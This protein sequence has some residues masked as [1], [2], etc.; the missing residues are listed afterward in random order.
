MSGS[1]VFCIGFPKTGTTTLE[2]VLKSLGYRMGSQAHGE[3]LVESW[4]NRNFDPIKKLCDTADAFQDV[5]FGLP[6]TFQY[7]DSSYPDSKFILS[8][9]NNPDQWYRSVVNFH[10]KLWSADKTRPPSLSELKK[11]NYN[12]LG[13][14]YNSMKAIYNTTDNDI[15]NRERLIY[16]YLRHIDNVK[17][18]FTRIPDR[19]II[20]NVSID[21]DYQRMI[22][23]LNRKSLLTRFPHKNKT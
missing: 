10:S 14:A 3:S 1:K 21:E 22:C 7:L 6:Y 9:R 11:V 2:Y 17:E 16:V 20:I 18:Y 23:F 19:L 12:G 13:W 5:P 15:Y 4:D 8:I